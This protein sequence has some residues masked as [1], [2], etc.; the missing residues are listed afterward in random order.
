M[1]YRLSDIDHTD[2]KRRNITTKWTLIA[3]PDFE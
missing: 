1:G 2:E 3:V